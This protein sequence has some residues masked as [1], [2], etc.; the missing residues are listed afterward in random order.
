MTELAPSLTKRLNPVR[1]WMFVIYAV[2][3]PNFVRF[4]G[5]GR[6]HKEG[7]FNAASESAIALTL[8]TGFIFA[9]ITLLN[10]HRILQRRI[11]IAA[12]LWIVLAFDLVVTS[13]LEPATRLTPVAP[14]DLLLSLYRLAEWALA[15]L[16]LLSLYTR[17]KP[18][19]ATD[20]SVRLIAIVCWVNVI[21]VWIALPLLPSLVYAPAADGSEANPRL[22]GL[23]IHPGHL[24]LLAGVAFFHALMF[25][26]GPKR[27]AACL[28]AFVTVVLTYARAELI[29]L[30]ISLAIY[31]VILSRSAALRWFGVSLG[32]VLGGL[33]IALREQA[34][35]YLERGQSL[36][37]ITTLSERT[38]VWKASAQAFA[39][40][41]ILGYGFIAGPRHA[42]LDY[43]H[44]TNWVPP[45]AHNEFLQALLS[46]GV[47]AGLLI[48]AIYG[49]AWWAGLC[50]A[51]LGPKHAF[52]LIVLMQCTLL[53]F[54][55][56][57]ITSQLSR[58]GVVFLLTF[59]GLVG[60]AKDPI[61]ARYRGPAGSRQ[62][63]GFL[64]P[65]P[66]GQV[67]GRCRSS[68]FTPALH[69][70]GDRTTVQLRRTLLAGMLL[71]LP[72]AGL[73][74]QVS[75]LA[76]PLAASA[77]GHPI[78]RSYFG[79]NL[80]G[81]AWRDSWPSVDV[82][83]VRIF[84]SEWSKIEP[85]RGVWDF[86]HLDYDVN[87][88]RTHHAEAELVLDSTPTWA[89]ARPGET[90]SYA[91]EPPGSRAE[92]RSLEDWESYVR[93]IATRYK[94]RVH[95]Y[96]MWNEPNMKGSF[97]GDNAQLIGLCHA[98]YQTLKRVDPS[99]IVV[100]PSP[101]PA[102]GSLW[103]HSFIDGGGRGTFDVLGYHFYDNLGAP[104][105]HPESLIGAAQHLRLML[106]I[107][108]LP[109]TPIWNTEAGYYIHSSSDAQTQ[110]LN[111]PPHVHVL[112][113]QEGAEVVAR[114]YA[115]AWGAGIERFYWY[116]WGEAEYAIAD[117][118]GR[119]P[120]AAT[121]AY[122]TMARWLIGAT[123][124]S[125]TSADTGDWIIAM[126]GRSGAL[127]FL[128]WT[129]N[130]SASF[131]IPPSWHVSR[132]EDLAGAD[133]RLSGS[134]I[135]ITSAPILVY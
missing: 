64:P 40:R 123:Y 117:D 68:D 63:P 105:V 62:W 116:G 19:S 22:G 122:S 78:P 37:T 102:G 9:A 35:R 10:R 84:D 48:T 59:L 94:G 111:Y 92:P 104:Q 125:V 97:T 5:S 17:E 21:I 89:S 120:K 65:E 127:Q 83:A 2:G 6:T 32:L 25:L 23:M 60:T 98:A 71:A 99:I 73:R 101:A 27:I 115:L 28:L 91:W 45:H 85:H 128:V 15:F 43:W 67:T 70:D 132:M 20:F 16:L 29:V 7:L 82:G 8:T 47:V 57:L 106:H 114:C 1:Y 88:A 34:L 31:V 54:T 90:Y 46:G 75:S 126:R 86:S 26:R 66:L 30:V 3:L 131:T 51:R 77:T 44:A 74:A 93:T 108:G 41:P 81:A 107:T 135:G 130:H 13:F 33:A 14:T 53:A 61:V 72:F 109:E 52:L 95:I 11:N 124:I 36:R 18:E 12:A 76:I 121:V 113:Q 119:T 133:V 69:N 112:S 129:L 80:A 134:T 79:M 58:I 38:L 42:I 56:P 39:A 110:I 87:A 118:G 96:E 49:R 103:L 24:S 50:Q 55:M 4:D 100:S